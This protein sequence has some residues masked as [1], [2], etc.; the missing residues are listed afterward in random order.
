[1]IYIVDTHTLIWYFTGDERLGKKAK[2]I[3]RRGGRGQ[4]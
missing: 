4:E 3:L 1:M 2:D